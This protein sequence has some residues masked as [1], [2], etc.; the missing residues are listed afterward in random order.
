M[1]GPSTAT[2]L[3]RGGSGYA[4]DRST[5]EGEGVYALQSSM[6]RWMLARAA[7]G[8]FTSA[9]VRREFPTITKDQLATHLRVLCDLGLLQLAQK[10]QVGSHSRTDRNQYVLADTSSLRG[11]HAWLGDLL[12]A[13]PAGKDRITHE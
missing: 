11:L 8:S 9:D 4:L 5:P 13:D 3:A 1:S 12:Q 2:R 10:R 6:R 7:A